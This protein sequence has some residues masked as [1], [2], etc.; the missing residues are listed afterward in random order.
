MVATVGL[1]VAVVLELCPV[2][3]AAGEVVVSA[4][5]RLGTAHRGVLRVALGAPGRQEKQKSVLESTDNSMSIF[6]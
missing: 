4:A 6:E 5:A 2:L 3:E 1:E